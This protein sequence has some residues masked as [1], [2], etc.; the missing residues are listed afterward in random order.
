M[1]FHVQD[2]LRRS[3]RNDFGLS[4]LQVSNKSPKHIS[5]SYF[6]DFLWVREDMDMELRYDG[7]Q[8]KDDMGLGLSL[9]MNMINLVRVLSVLFY[10]TET[11]ENFKLSY[12]LFKNR[13][14]RKT[15][16]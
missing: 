4:L 10:V 12:I 11:Q 9:L 3:Q 2:M 15:P 7:E 13:I 8:V 6:L 5:S 1:I 14:W 16:L